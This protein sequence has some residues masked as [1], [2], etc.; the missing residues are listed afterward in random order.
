MTNV[1]KILAAAR[2]EIGVKEYPAN[3]NKVKYNTW[4][5]GKEV[6]GEKYP[7]C[8][9]FQCWLF[10]QVGMSKLFYDGEKTA[11]C[12]ALETWARKNNMWKTTGQKGDLILFD[13][14]GKGEAGH[15][16]IVEEVNSSQY[17]TIEGNTSSSS[18]SNGGAVERRK[19]SGS[20]IRGFIRI[21]YE[22]VSNEQ[23][24]SAQDITYSTVKDGKCTGEGVN[25]RS[26]AGL[27]YKSYGTV[28][29]NASLKVYGYINKTID[30]HVW[31]KVSGSNLTGYMS[32][33]YINIITTDTGNTYE[34]KNNKEYTILPDIGVNVRKTASVN[35]TK[36]SALKKGTKVTCLGITEK[37]ENG[38]LYYWMKIS[39]GYICAMENFNKY[40]G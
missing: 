40:V 4:Y 39:S 35:G 7:W 24:T 15:I 8:A 5:Y 34:W 14:T 3:S 10:N 12:P 33:S 28:K 2:N 13:F 38:K 31:Y 9:A 37:T 23:N 11:Y 6:S 27:S 30:G 22:N 18:N 29:K 19:R 16:G 20:T 17:T 21:K 32:G 26:G 36:V 1:E 25:I